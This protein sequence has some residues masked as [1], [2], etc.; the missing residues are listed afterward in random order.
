MFRA[1]R[2][3][4][5]HPAVISRRWTDGKS[6]VPRRRRGSIRPWRLDCRSRPV[7][8]RYRVIELYR[9]S[10]G[11]AR[12]D[13]AVRQSRFFPVPKNAASPPRARNL[14]TRGPIWARRT[15]RPRLDLLNLRPSSGGCVRRQR[16]FF[17]PEHRPGGARSTAGPALPIRCPR[18][19]R[20]RLGKVRDGGS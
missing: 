14:S 6:P 16:A 2:T 3:Q 5:R 15:E 1:R 19:V 20:V 10:A 13:G 9:T 12:P 8:R 4:S 17:H 11:P 7:A 18:A